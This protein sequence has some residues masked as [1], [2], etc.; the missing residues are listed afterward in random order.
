MFKISPSVGEDNII[1][2]I[3]C[4]RESRWKSRQLMWMGYRVNIKRKRFERKIWY[5]LKVRWRNCDDGDKSRQEAKLVELV[6][7]ENNWRMFHIKITL[8]LSRRRGININISWILKPYQRSNG[9]EQSCFG[10][11]Q[12]IYFSEANQ[13]LL[14][15]SFP[16]LLF[17]QLTLI[18]LPSRVSLY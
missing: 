2:S 16:F 4:V 5:K 3:V 12:C 10:L 11:W 1:L 8:L 15:V 7:D 17:S 14:E 6:E 9:F 18:Y 13:L